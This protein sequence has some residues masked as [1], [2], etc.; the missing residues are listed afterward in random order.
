VKVAL[1]LT[2]E[3]PPGVVTVRLTFPVP[4]GTV[5]V[6]MVAED[7]TTFGPGVAPKAT[8][9]APVRFLPLMVTRVPPSWEPDDGLTEVTVGLAVAALSV[10]LRAFALTVLVPTTDSPNLYLAALVV[11]LA[12]TVMLWLTVPEVHG[13][14]AG[15][16][17]TVGTEEK[18]QE[19]ALL[20]WAESNTGPPAEP[21]EVGVAAKPATVGAV[22]VAL[23]AGAAIAP[24]DATG[25]AS[26]PA[27]STKPQPT[28]TATHFRRSNPLKVIVTPPHL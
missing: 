28:G 15:S 1:V 14:V 25:A 27:I 26:K 19:E 3:V 5:A 16:P 24:A 11:A 22:E 17:A 7:A 8:A 4:A 9:V 23:A 10:S 20:T 12:G 6:T 13:T 18:T 2:G 21:S